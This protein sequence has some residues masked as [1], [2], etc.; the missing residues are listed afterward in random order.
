[1]PTRRHALIALVLVTLAACSG[2]TASPPG[3]ANPT[4]S[5]APTETDG[6]AHP[7]GATDIV[8]R[9]EEGGGFVPVEFLAT[10]A[11]SFTL[12]GDG[13]VVF[14]NP[15][16]QAPEMNDGLF[17]GIPFSIARIP[18]AKVQELLNFAIT[19]GGLGVA[20]ERY[21]NAQVAD[22][23]TSTF[24][25][26]AGGRT[27]TV[28]VYALGMEPPDDPEAA[29]RRAFNT[30][31]ERLRDF[32]AAGDLTTAAYAPAAYR[33]TLIEAQGAGPA[34]IAWPWPAV[35]VSDFKNP[36]DP[37]ALGFPRRVMSLE[38]IETLGVAKP[39][40]GVQGLYLKSPDDKIYSFSLRPLLPD[41][42]S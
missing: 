5:P 17:R 35:K 28:A 12:Y 40:G 34:I 29:I 38:E 37:N 3:S 31:A 32:D 9:L 4:S 8:L 7:T 11:P 27:K 23:S 16:D 25:I 36:G 19:E 24:T 1:M 20:R 30:L 41:E 21:D 2:P 15:A 26:Q 13:T 39:E 14:R 6:I 18:E 42:T 33:G 10:N 22:A